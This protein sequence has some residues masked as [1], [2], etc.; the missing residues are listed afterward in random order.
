MT[1]E[2][3]TQH[4]RRCRQATL[5]MLLEDKWA[6]DQRRGLRECCW[7]QTTGVTLNVSASWPV[8][9]DVARMVVSPEPV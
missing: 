5:V 6:R 2:A 3:A 1:T 8:A 4:C 9:S 7:D